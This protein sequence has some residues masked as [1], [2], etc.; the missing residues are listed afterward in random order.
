MTGF[1]RFCRALVYP[2]VRV[3]W[4]VKFENVEAMPKTGGVVLCSNHISALDPIFLGIALK[5]QVYYMGK[6][7]LFNNKLLAKFFRA[8]GAFAVNRGKGDKA[9]LD[10][11]TSIIDEGHVMGIFPEGTRSK[12]GELLRAKSGTLLIASRANAPILVAAIKTKDQK[13][14]LF[15]PVT[16]RFGKILTPDELHVE[17]TSTA[18]IRAASKKLMEEIG[19]LLID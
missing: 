19:A 16:V 17:L 11:G 12:T 1:Y 14:R 5:R 7:E 13:V 8:L 4:R 2:F 10:T 18:T 3:L 15:R 9:A 6:Q